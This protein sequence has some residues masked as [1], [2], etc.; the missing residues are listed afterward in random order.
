MSEG[1]VAWLDLR[2]LGCQKVDSCMRLQERIF[3][4]TFHLIA[5]THVTGTYLS[6]ELQKAALKHNLMLLTCG[7]DTT[8]Y[9]TL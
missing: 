3:R 5:F 2:H 1:P 7:N 8:R 6:K 9:A 4:I